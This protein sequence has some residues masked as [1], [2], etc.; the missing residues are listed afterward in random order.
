V[1]GQPLVTENVKPHTLTGPSTEPA[2]LDKR[3]PSLHL[4]RAAVTAEIDPRE[5]PAKVKRSPKSPGE[6]YEAEEDLV[7][8]ARID[9]Q[10]LA[11]KYEKTVANPHLSPE[12]KKRQLEPIAKEARTTAARTRSTIIG[13]HIE[14][15]SPAS[16]QYMPTILE[17][18]DHQLDWPTKTFGPEIEPGVHAPLDISP[19]QKVAH[20]ER[21]RKS[22]IS[23]T[24]GKKVERITKGTEH[25][26]Y[27]LAVS[28][29]AVVAHDLLGDKPVGS[30]WDSI[31]EF[32]GKLKWTRPPFMLP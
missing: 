6:R 15:G 29:H 5:R 22:L 4:D 14:E 20:V 10:R 11:R 18:L 23:G 12:E 24:K 30:L 2:F 1:Y 27:H 32:D 31:V 19:A 21:L 25:D 8:K 26:A 16:R 17:N 13:S 7:N 9:I 28:N 3:Q